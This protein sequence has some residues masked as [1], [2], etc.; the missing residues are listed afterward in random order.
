M[1]PEY[2]ARY[3]DLS[4]W[5]WW[6]RG[7]QRIVEAVLHK[8]LNKRK[9]LR[10]ASVGCGP[11]E[12]LFW[13]APLAEPKGCVLGVD[14]DQRHAVA[15]HSNIYYVI[16]QLEATPLLTGA[17]DVVLA[18]DVLEHVDDDAAGLREAVRLLNPAGLLVVTV[19]AFPS[20]W[21][22]QDVVNQHRRRYT[23]DALHEVFVRA[24]LPRPRVSY[25][26]SIL[27][28]PIAAIRWARRALGL[29]ERARTD[30]ED[31]RPGLVNEALAALFGLE[32][33]LVDRIPMP[34]GVSLLAVV[35]AAP[36]S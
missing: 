28:P 29:N 32:R 34:W 21:G 19:P 3:G 6:F 16:G 9:S 27:F 12:G 31:N 22:S 36:R 10:I 11:V 24:H 2:A 13:L 7:R 35:R 17:F 14:P 15:S 25:F 26:N 33:Y 30:F 23:K 20:L 5:H 18:L 4:R 8:E 1:R